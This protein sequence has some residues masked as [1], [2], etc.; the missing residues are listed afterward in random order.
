MFEANIS[1]KNSRLRSNE[2][3]GITLKGWKRSSIY[4]AERTPAALRNPELLL[5]DRCAILPTE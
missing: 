1:V 2:S 4:E 3:P 5:R